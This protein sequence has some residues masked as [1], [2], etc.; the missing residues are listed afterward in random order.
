MRQGASH[1]IQNS[2][3]LYSGPEE[4]EGYNLRH[5][6]IVLALCLWAAPAALRAQVPQGTVERI[7]VLNIQ[8]TELRFLSN[9]AQIDDR[10][11]GLR[12]API[13]AE[14]ATLWQEVR[15]YA[16]NDQQDAER[17]I[18]GLTNA[19]LAL[20]MPQ[21]QAKAE[22]V[23]EQRE[24]HDRAVTAG[25]PADVRAAL[26]PQ[27]RRLLLQLRRDRGEITE[28]DYAA[29]DKKALD[30]IMA[31][32]SKYLSD[33]GRFVGHFDN[34]LRNMT[35]AIA[36]N[37]A[38]PLP[39]PQVRAG[40]GGTSAGDYQR[41]V[42][43]AADLRAQR[44]KL[45]WRLHDEQIAM[46]T[47]RETDKILGDD[48]VR[49]VEKWRAA[50]KGDSFERDYQR[51]PAPRLANSR[52]PQRPP[53]PIAPSAPAKGNPFA[54]FF[55]IF[56]G[57]AFVLLVVAGGLFL[58]FR[59]KVQPPLSD[60][61]GT[62]Q[63]AP[64]QTD[65]CDERSIRHGVFLG[66]SAIPGVRGAALDARGAPV[67]TTPEH[68]T[69]IV[70]RTGTGKGTRVIVPTLLRYAGSALVIDPKGENAA[71]TARIRRDELG[72]EVYILNPWDEL[73][74]TYSRLGFSPA[75]YNPLEVLEWNDSN[76]VAIAQALA[77]SI[78]PRDAKGKDAFWNASAASVLTAVLLWLTDQ[79]REKKTLARAREIVSLSRK[80]FTAKYLIHMA[81]SEAYGGA[82]REMA[83]P[84]MDMADVTYSGV[85]S[86]LS[87]HTRF[88]SDPRI[89]AAT[90]TSS[91]NFSMMSLVDEYTTVY[92]VIPPDRIDT[93]KTWLRLVVTA[94]MHTFKHLPPDNPPRHRSLFFIDE[95]PALGRL[96]EIP[97]D[98]ATM[99]GY[100]VDFALVVQ[101]LDQ[102]KDHY[103]D[104]RG[105][106][107]SNCA[108]KWFCNVNDLESAKYLSDTLGKKTVQTVSRSESAS[109]GTRSA[110][111]T[112]GTTFAETGRNLLNPDEIIN[113]GKDV[114]IA[115]QPDGYAL[116]LRPVDYWNLPKAF[117]RIRQNCPGLYW[118]PPLAYDE[119]PYF[120]PAGGGKPGAAS[121]AAKE[122]PRSIPQ[123]PPE[124]EM[125]LEEAREILDVDEFADRDTIIAHYSFLSGV[126][127]PKHLPRMNEARKVLL[128]SLPPEDGNPNVQ[129]P[130]DGAK[131]EE[132][133]IEMA[134]IV[135][136]V[137][138]RATRRTVLE[139]HRQMA[140]GSTP[141]AVAW[142]DKALAV[143]L[144]TVFQEDGDYDL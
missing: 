36:R 125:T 113:L 120:N 127:D 105:A 134:R 118:Q 35:E 131:M 117:A 26:E 10:T 136:N 141:E 109:D 112:H 52:Q 42:A 78:C 75:T 106:I 6:A 7:A 143:L 70:A 130:T 4:V 43:L 98:I 19:R 47:F 99:R 2:T 27:R 33:G 9:S 97:R 11:A 87:Q 22:Q 89:K 92:V 100:G 107:L 108:Y 101:G 91:S 88:L 90:A 51:Q 29:E 58:L 46:P 30:E 82:I 64:W 20:L 14:L 69:L 72:Q 18:T 93:Q 38:T 71:I 126:I 8:A 41:D 31:I 15:Q 59:K 138:E 132:L 50:G 56:F 63:F 1:G 66:K 13:D 54:D 80:D 144:P 17:K 32:R 128:G 16:E 104:S 133:S 53:G 65:T 103:G 84:F 74:L 37:P 25:I 116:Y 62:A 123:S 119:N 23:K 21:W 102:L 57:V 55:R 49:L 67:C 142:L 114:A 140:A 73:S 34:Q 68:H 5:S 12:Q 44:D 85:M 110:S 139:R 40:Q 95:F 24:Q 60:V 83:S 81:A 48:L 86:N 129:P 115:L 28:A 122:K 94:A 45:A 3:F 77:D 124:D 137:D 121:K 61:Y 135:L 39:V 111:T 76:V 96:D 79:P